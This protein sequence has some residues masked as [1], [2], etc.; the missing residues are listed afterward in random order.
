MSARIHMKVSIEFNQERYIANQYHWVDDD[1]AAKLV[2]DGKAE[3]AVGRI[4]LIEDME[5]SQ[6]PPVDTRVKKEVAERA[7]QEEQKE[8]S[9]PK[10][11]SPIKRRRKIGG[12]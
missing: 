8:K 5:G 3:Y 12:I 9:K 2:A 6:N 7:G 4:Q 1:I 10:R 11:T